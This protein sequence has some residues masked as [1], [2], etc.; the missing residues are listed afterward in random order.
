MNLLTDGIVAGV[1]LLGQ[2]GVTLPLGDIL[3]FLFRDSGAFPLTD[4]GALLLRYVLKDLILDSVTLSLIDNLALGHGTGGADLL[5]HGLTL[6]LVPGGAGLGSLSG[7]GFIVMS[8]LDGSWNIDTLKVLGV[9]ALLLLLD[10]TLGADIIDRGTVLLDLNRTFSSL[11]L[12]LNLLLN[13]LA[14]FVLDIGTGLV[15]NF[16]ALLPGHRLKGGSRNLVTNLLRNL[17][18]Y[19]L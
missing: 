4:H 6:V 13:D 2:D 5:L 18:T 9:V 12:F 7:T 1:T 3:V 10:G 11:D 14:G 19:R 15:R 16:S 17:S 8:F